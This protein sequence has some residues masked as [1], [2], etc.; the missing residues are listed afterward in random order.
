MVIKTTN[1][2]SRWVAIDIINDTIIAEGVEPNDA[3]EQAEKLG[4]EFSLM[5]VPKPGVT[6]IL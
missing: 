3:V 1:P 6:Y 4:V 2:D 5:F